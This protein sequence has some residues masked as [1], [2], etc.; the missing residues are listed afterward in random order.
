MEVAVK[1]ELQQVSRV[2]SRLAWAASNPRI[3]EPQLLQIEHADKSID[4]TNWIIVI[5]VVFHARRQ[6]TRLLTAHAGLEGVIRHK[7][8]RTLIGKFGYEFLP[9]LNASPLRTERGPP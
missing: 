7:T 2:I 4:R 9:S 6:K 3:A 8:N 5:D 1:I